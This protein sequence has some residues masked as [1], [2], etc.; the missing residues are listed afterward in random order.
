[1][2]DFLNDLLPTLA[3]IALG[4]FL[5]ARNVLGEA[6]VEG[7]RKLIST[8]TLPAVMFAAFSRLEPSAG[9]LALAAAVFAACAL[10]GLAGG[11][12]G[13]ALRLPMPST[14]F[15]FQGYEAGMLGYALFG[16]FFGSHNLSAFAGADLGQVVY[17]FTV[18]FTMLTAR[19]SA[20]GASGSADFGAEVRAAALRILSSPVMIAIIAGLLS[21][22]FIP[23]ARGLPWGED[24]F[25]ASALAAVGGITSPLVCMVVG[26]SLRSGIRGAASAAATVAARM[27]FSAVAGS[28]I[29][30]VLVPALGF[31]RMQSMAVLVLFMLPPPFVIPVLRKAPEESAYVGAVLSLHTL[32][33][34]AAVAALAAFGGRA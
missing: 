32:L 14:A 13:K 4:A 3:L 2:P 24:G 15:L 18:L 21:A 28:F 5:G 11:V 25:L 8:V 33:S 17:V 16:A 1:M 22:A 19:P 10:L 23:G 34:L 27:L 7:F 30:F 6:A 12:I 26:F 31:G 29:A 9:H 20:R